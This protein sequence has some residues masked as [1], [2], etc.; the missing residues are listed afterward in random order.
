MQWSASKQLLYAI[1]SLACVLNNTLPAEG[2]N[3][4]R[5]CQFISNYAPVLRDSDKNS[6]LHMTVDLAKLR[7]EMYH[8]VTKR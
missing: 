8:Y 2:T 7:A 6:V 4:D 5:L 1:Y 3:R